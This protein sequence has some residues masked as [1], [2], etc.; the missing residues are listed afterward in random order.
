MSKMS[1]LDEVMNEEGVLGVFEY[2]HKKGF[3][4]AFGIIFSLL[5]FDTITEEDKLWNTQKEMYQLK[6]LQECM[7]K[8]VAGLEQE[9]YPDGSQLELLQEMERRLEILN[10]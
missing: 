9:S 6:L 2:G 3:E 7:G 5:S 8:T 10:K 4:D 1:E